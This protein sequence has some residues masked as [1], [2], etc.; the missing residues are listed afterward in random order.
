[1]NSLTHDESNYLNA[2]G[3]EH[4]EVAVSENKHPANTNT[5]QHVSKHEQTFCNDVSTESYVRGYN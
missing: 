3:L 2:T 4:K 1:M 5:Q